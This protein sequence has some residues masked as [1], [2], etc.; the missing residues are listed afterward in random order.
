MGAEWKKELLQEGY[1]YDQLD[2][3]EA[4]MDSGVDVSI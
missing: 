1:S 3:I 2:E 4:G